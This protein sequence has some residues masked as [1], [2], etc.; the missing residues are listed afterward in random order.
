MEKI[1]RK[2]FKM[3]ATFLVMTLI[4]T[5]L[6]VRK[7]LANDEIITQPNEYNFTYMV[8][9]DGTIE[10]I[11]YIGQNDS[12]K[13]IIIPDK[14]FGREVTSVNNDF[15]KY[16]ITGKE[17]VIF[18]KSIRKLGNDRTSVHLTNNMGMMVESQVI[19]STVDGLEELVM[20][21]EANLII[22]KVNDDID[23][24]LEEKIKENPLIE[25]V[26]ESFY[27]TY[28]KKEEV[29]KEFEYEVM[30]NEEI[31]I[32]KY[33]GSENKVEIPSTINGY[34]VV[35][36]GEG[37]F[38]SSNVYDITI[39]DT[40][41]VLEKNVFNED[42][43][44]YR[45]NLSKNLVYI[46]GGIPLD[47]IAEINVTPATIEDTLSNEEFSEK[48]RNNSKYEI[49]GLSCEINYLSNSEL[50]EEGFVFNLVDKNDIYYKDYTIPNLDYTSI[51]I[52][53]YRGNKFQITYPK[54]ILNRNVYSIDRKIY[55]IN[56]PSME[57]MQYGD[58]NENVTNVTIS[59]G[60]K[61]IKYDSLNLYP[62]L[63]D[64]TLTDELWDID[65]WY[66]YDVKI[67][68]VNIFSNSF[69]ETERIKNSLR[70]DNSVDVQVFPL[71]SMNYDNYEYETFSDGI[72]IILDL[73]KLEKDMIIPSVIEGCRVDDAS[74]VF[75]SNKLRD[76]ELESLTIPKKMNLSNTAGASNIKIHNIYVDDNIDVI[77]LD[78]MLNQLSERGVDIASSR[79]KNIYKYDDNVYEK[80][81][82]KYRIPYYEDSYYH[83]LNNNTISLERT[84]YDGLIVPEYYRG[85]KVVSVRLK[86][87]G[88]QEGNKITIPASLKSVSIESINGK[89][90]VG[91]N[92]S[93][94]GRES[95]IN[96]EEFYNL[97]D[98]IG[99]VNGTGEWY[100]PN[101]SNV[102]INEYDMDRYNVSYED[103]QY[104]VLKDGTLKINKYIG[105]S[106]EVKIPTYIYGHKVTALSNDFIDKDKEYS[107]LYIPVTVENFEGQ[108]PCNFKVKELILVGKVTG[109]SFNSLSK[110]LEKVN[111]SYS[112]MKIIC[113]KYKKA[114]A[115][116]ANI[117]DYEKTYNNK[118]SLKSF[119]GNEKVTEIPKIGNDIDIE[120]IYLDNENS[121]IEELIVPNTVES[122]GYVDGAN[123]KEVQINGLEDI[124]EFLPLFL[125]SMEDTCKYDVRTVVDTVAP[126]KEDINVDGQ[127][128]L[129]D[130]ATIAE[131]YNFSKDEENYPVYMDLNND[132]VINIVDL[133]LVARRIS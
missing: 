13:D 45:A 80:I 57:Y 55:D 79:I 9:E 20:Y 96:Y 22:V 31:K 90:S 65:Q 53:Q 124:G 28:Y 88:Y 27:D 128:D 91:I 81:E 18:P 115:E 48:I 29:E 112:N 50:Q 25:L 103:F 107:K 17:R 122:I 34:K 127:V 38:A 130:L 111:I 92:I 72:A 6:P 8:K 32:T 126:I 85:Y 26:D 12:D 110:L 78:N 100:T 49:N 51:N 105:N 99:Q 33:L 73:K 82:D 125:H 36:L 98:G 97:M 3:V 113:D 62:N 76:K 59:R 54:R 70:I 37:A 40:V 123:L 132:G 118:V 104:E 121:N 39:P 86:D 108:E 2:K 61:S 16:V 94:V 87:N 14:L 119:E 63:S 101:Y 24:E 77:E 1:S 66:S 120:S 11:N 30:N 44:I 4:I 74:A 67:K 52:L 95:N 43:P 133:V 5:I 35:A 10:V 129:K 83:I 68:R 15:F 131:K 7:V 93:L 109:E 89:Y 60:I 42:Y 23:S 46:E 116:K 21:S 117:I 106:E 69:V 64:L 58:E 114:D 84:I 102:G 41:N 56:E 19:P 75:N 47:T 71:E